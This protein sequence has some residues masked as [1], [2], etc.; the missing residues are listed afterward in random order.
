MKIRAFGLVAALL[1]FQLG[2]ETP[3]V[4]QDAP[5][6]RRANISQP[7]RAR[8]GMVVSQSK[9]AS[10]VGAQILAD[11][12]NAVDAAV[13]TALALAVVLPRAGNLGGGG[14]IVLAGP[15]FEEPVALDYREMAPA[16]ATRDMYLDADGNVD[17]D[18]AMRSIFSSGVPGTVRGL[19]LALADY[20][21]MS[22]EEV[23][24]PAY[25]LAHDGFVASFEFADGLAARRERL[26]GMPAGRQKFYKST[27]DNYV[28]GDIF[29]QPVLADTLAQLMRDGPDA[30][31]TGDIARKIADFMQAQGGLITMDDLANYR[32]VIR[33]PVTGTYR[34]FE[35]VS[36]PPPSS[37]G[38]HIIQMLNI[39]ENYPIRDMGFGSADVMHLMAEAMRR[40]FADR[41]KHLGDPDYYDVPLEWLTDKAY[42]AELSAKIDM[43]RATP[44]SEV[45]PGKPP[46]YESMDTT[47]LSVMD[48]R[49]NAVSLTT[50][51]NFSYG[52]GIVVP[53]AGF[54]LNNEMDD[55][56]SKPGVPN[57]FGLLGGDAN[58]IEG[59]KR[60]LSSMTP[61]I[62]LRDGRP[63]LVTGSPGGSRIIT[64]VLQIIVNVIDHGMNI[65]DAVVAPRMHHQWQPDI[66][67]VEPGFSPDTLSLLEARGHKLGRG[68]VMGAGESILYDGGIFYGAADPRRPFS[69]AAGVC[70]EGS[71]LAC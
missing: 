54:L 35:I 39:L 68:R 62:V 12:G 3:A 67:Q 20:G 40:A 71:V 29:V 8:E 17:R 46:G 58:A 30:F 34:G 9:L 47:Q 70:V 6:V 1:I 65:A 37:G 7:E 51:L 5:L 49:G 28:A 59:G 24:R 63:Y 2:V 25:L 61:T 48:G 31:Y 45:L 16:A 27:G 64:V 11:G 44:S 66:L 21:T 10:A 57:A 50:T 32:A 60:P 19:A 18:K 69:G 33:K 26:A 15:D 53:G 4:A 41:S 43:K 38:V 56:S 14:F 55:F 13:A 52:S 23:T 22:W 42:A 36:M